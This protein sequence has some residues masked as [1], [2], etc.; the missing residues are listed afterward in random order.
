MR[1]WSPKV[2]KLKTWLACDDAP[3]SYYELLG[4]P[5]FTDQR[6]VLLSGVNA[7][8][9]YFHQFQNHKAADVVQRARTLQLLCAR[10]AHTFSAEDSWKAY[11]LSLIEQ[12]KSEY[13]AHRT[14]S[15]SNDQSADL[16]KWLVEFR[17]VVRHRL[18]EVA[19]YLDDSR[20]SLK[21]DELPITVDTPPVGSGPAD[22][23]A[24]RS[25]NT[26]EFRK[27]E[28]ARPHPSPGPDQLPFVIGNY[29][30]L[31]RLG[32]GGN[33]IVYKARH[34]QLQKLVAI[35]LLRNDREVETTMIARFQREMKAIGKLDHVNIVRATDA[36]CVE[37]TLFLAMDLIDGQNLHEVVQSRGALPMKEACD[38]IRQAALGL[39]HAHDQQLVHRDI[40]PSNLMITASGVVKILDLG[41]ATLAPSALQWDQ[42]PGDRSSQLTAV[43]MIVGT[44]D[45][46]AP[47]QMGGQRK[48]GAPADIYSLGCT[49][50]YLLTGQP[51]F[52]DVGPNQ[53]S[54]MAAHA[55]EPIPSLARFR[56]DV[57]EGVEKILQRMMAKSP[58]DRYPSAQDVVVA[59]ES[60]L[61]A[62]PKRSEPPRVE[63]V[64]SSRSTP[65]ARPVL[66]PL[67]PS[68]NS[69]RQG[70]RSKPPPL[71][72][73]AVAAA[74]APVSPSI[75]PAGPRRRAAEPAP[76]TAQNIGKTA[77]MKFP[78][79]LADRQAAGGNRSEASLPAH[80]TNPTLPAQNSPGSANLMIWFAAGS[81]LAL[82]ALGGLW[83]LLAILLSSRR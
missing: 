64:A 50:F 26:K 70:S 83:L 17:G 71:P 34:V 52:G 24:F 25:A 61:S 78:P 37:E 6:D 15:G 23:S 36:G 33:G 4:E 47:E 40:K 38:L 68:G 11:D 8:A 79:T 7:A 75:D 35:K 10:A 43:G 72:T 48:V 59:L 55:C 74:T 44:I 29:E 16:R 42:E 14:A 5:L 39:Q 69:A 66:P 1:L 21:S 56:S 73:A 53:I 45:Y 54:R 76:D 30:V 67:T 31:Q 49:L 80:R 77:P 22:Q 32:S 41:L 27:P 18:D 19:G 12:L 82:A 3:S 2:D 65:S 81:L 57:P 60:A 63:A 20:E 9:K 58:Q 46:M 28:H 13:Q 62:A 51:V